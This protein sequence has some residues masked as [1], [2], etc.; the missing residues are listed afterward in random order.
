MRTVIRKMGNSQGVLI[1]KLVLE[2]I[3]VATGD[4]VD[5]KIN[6]KGRLVIAPLPSEPK[7]RWAEECRELAKAGEFG[8]IRNSG[9]GQ[10]RDW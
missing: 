6:K 10:G 1:P 8:L 9:S 5:L 2:Q 4:P 3:G 7:H